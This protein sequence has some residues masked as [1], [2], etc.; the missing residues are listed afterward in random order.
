MIKV[1]GINFC[2]NIKGPKFEVGWGWENANK[3]FSPRV[4]SSHPT[5]CHAGDLQLCE[6]A[7]KLR[8]YRKKGVRRF[9]AFFYQTISYGSQL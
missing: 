4:R 1:S 2:N 7:K 5:G 8:I 6:S 3:K 9:L